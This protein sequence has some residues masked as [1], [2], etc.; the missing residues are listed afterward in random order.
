MRTSSKRHSVFRLA[1]LTMV[2]TLVAFST[3]IPA[4]INA[5]DLEV[6]ILIYS[7]RTN[8]SYGKSSPRGAIQTTSLPERFVT[9]V[10]G[11]QA[12]SMCCNST[13]HLRN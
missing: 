12:T 9:T 1:A 8:P 11:G 3:P 2:L 5:E 13:S 4:A 10:P 6:R 7:G